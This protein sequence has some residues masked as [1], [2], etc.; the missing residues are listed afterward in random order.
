MISN[1]GES[2]TCV[3]AYCLVLTAERRRDFP[4]NRNIELLFSLV[5]LHIL[6]VINYE[7]YRHIACFQ[8]CRGSV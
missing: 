7:I 6:P 2:S 8:I 1:G 3:M 4:K 5:V